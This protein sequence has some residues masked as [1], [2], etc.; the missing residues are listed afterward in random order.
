MSEEE[1]KRCWDAVGELIW[2]GDE[3]LDAVKDDQS[4]QQLFQK[5]DDPFFRW[6]S[7]RDYHLADGT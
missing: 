1:V 5:A 2:K 4:L 3:H 7:P 6:D